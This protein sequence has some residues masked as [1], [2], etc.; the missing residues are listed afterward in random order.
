MAKKLIISL[1]IVFFGITIIGI[2]L[3]AL[4]VI[5]TY[6]KLPPLNALTDYKPKIPLRI[7]SEDKVLIG[8]FWRRKTGICSHQSSSTHDD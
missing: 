1:F 6:P 2:S 8:E 4:A 3:A 7:F 5:V